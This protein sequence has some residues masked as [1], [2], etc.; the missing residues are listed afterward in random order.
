MTM[1]LTTSGAIVLK[2][3]AGANAALII[4]GAALEKF[5][6][7]AEAVLNA[8]TRKDWV[9]GYGGVG[10][11]FK[12]ILDDTCSD[13][14]A[15]KIISYDMSGYSSKSE[16]TTMLDFLKDNSTRNIEVLKD[17]KNKEVMD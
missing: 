4:S 17:E 14:A 16:A 9:A 8:A 10:A 12:A 6:L 15:M 2:A 11:N 13:L 7:Q 1:T 3:G 5:A